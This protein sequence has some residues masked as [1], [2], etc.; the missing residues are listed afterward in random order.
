MLRITLNS[1]L[2][3]NYWAIFLSSC[4]CV[5]SP[6]QQVCQPRRGKRIRPVPAQCVMKSLLKRVV[7]KLVMKPYSVRVFAP[8]GYTVQYRRCA[9]LSKKAF[10]LACKSTTPFLCPNCK[11]ERQSKDISTFKSLVDKLAGEIDT[12]KVSLEAKPIIKGSQDTVH[13]TDEPSENNNQSSHVKS[14]ARAVTSNISLG[15]IGQHKPKADDRKYK[16]WFC[17]VYQSVPKAP[18]RH[19]R[20]RKDMEDAGEVLSCID[21]SVTGKVKSRSALDWESTMRRNPAL[22]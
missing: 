8:I 2:K 14:Y 13:A 1:K 22:F 3:A 4:L 21:P 19:L 10:D 18:P 20:I 15:G 16:Y 6:L 11:L 12:L 9:G 7:N 5:L 17:L